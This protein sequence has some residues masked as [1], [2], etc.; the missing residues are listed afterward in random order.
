M[1]GWSPSFGTA[2]PADAGDVNGDVSMSGGPTGVSGDLLGE[3]RRVALASGLDRVGVCDASVLERA[4]AELF[5]RKEQG[6]ADTMQFT[7]RNPERS[8]DPLRTLPRARSIIVGARTYHRTEHG[9]EHM[10]EL[11][12]DRDGDDRDAGD[13]DAGDRDAVWA[14]IARY[15]QIDHYAALR[16][17]LEAVAHALRE[18]GHEAVVVADENNLVD[19]E[20]AWKAGLG[21]FGK[22][23]NLLLPGA[24]SWFVLGSVITSADLADVTEQVS[25]G[26]G[27]CRRCIDACPTGAIVADGVI[28]ARKCLAWLLQ[29]PGAFPME[30]RV[31]LGDRLYGCDD[32]QDSCPIT[33][34]LGPRH[35]TVVSRD[36]MSA[37][38]IDDTGSH[39]DVLDVLEADDAEVMARFGR[40]YIPERNP[41][42][43]R[44]NALIILGNVAPI[45][46]TH[47][48]TKVLERYA[49]ADEPHLRAQALWSARR[50]GVD[51]LVDHLAHDED[52]VVREE[53]NATDRVVR[54]PTG[55][56]GREPGS[57][58]Q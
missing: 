38:R 8:T 58:E 4:R 53:W 18:A 26:C 5:R 11:H 49:R 54:R 56:T 9:A 25:D 20:V 17:G 19:R 3:V 42:W 35:T 46:L 37:E 52:P 6:L 45:P 16:S 21:W 55:E 50:L 15:A 33:V 27:S 23:A 34:R 40:W 32:C 30:Y 51:H 48:T 10:P 28:D 41:V 31:D 43:V 47:R 22:N 57:V 39:V 44:R 14:R 13:R 7:F 24:G 2:Q 1:L 29:K 12:D 36:D